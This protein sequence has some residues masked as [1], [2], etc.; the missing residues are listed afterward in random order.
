ML[1]SVSGLKVWY[2]QGNDIIKNADFS[3]NTNQVTGLLGVNGSGKTTLL[4]V[5]A[6]THNKYTLD[7]CCFNGEKVKFSDTSYKLQ[8]YVVFT[9]EQAFMYWTFNDYFKFIHKLYN[10]HMD[11]NYLEYLV[12]G[13]EFQKYVNY[14][15]KDL[16]SGNKKKAFLITGFS[17]GLSLLIMDEPLDGLDFNSSEFLYEAINGYKSKGSILM[18][19]HI[20]ESFEKTCDRLLLLDDGLIQSKV[21]KNGTDIRKALE[22]WRRE[23]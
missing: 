14:M 8:R 11:E 2:Q 9:E 16:S 1:L 10:K 4:N 23:H 13:F 15:L 22:V 21:I 3:L 7:S 20:A 5:L 18:S 19:S 6:S 12:D 17:L